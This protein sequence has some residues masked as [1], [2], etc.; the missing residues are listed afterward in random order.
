MATRKI[1]S[2]MYTEHSKKKKSDQKLKVFT[3]TFSNERIGR[4]TIPYQL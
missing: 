1:S 3:D 4:R 2:K